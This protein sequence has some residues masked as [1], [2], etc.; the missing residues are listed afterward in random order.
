MAFRPQTNRPATLARREA[1][2]SAAAE[3]VAERG[4]GAVTHREVAARAELPLSATSYFFASI[5]ELVLEALRYF[6]AGLIE[7]VADVTEDISQQQFAPE[8]AVDLL[9]GALLAEPEHHV[10]AQFEAYL[11]VT[12]RPELRPAIQGVIVA[13]ERL[14]EATLTATGAKRPAEGSRA[15]VALIDGFALQRLAWPRGTSDRQALR[16]AMLAL[17]AAYTTD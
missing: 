8:A 3:L 15:F 10:I 2:L 14:A 11:E 1:L 6:I 13:L 7:R 16:A 17:H 5:D 12:R 4:V 9:L